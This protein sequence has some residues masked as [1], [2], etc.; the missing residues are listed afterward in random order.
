MVWSPP[1]VISL[2]PPSLD[3]G[4]VLDGGDGLADVE[5][6]DRHVAG[7]GHLL[8]GEGLHV[9]PG[10]VGPEQLGRGPDVSGPEPRTGP[11]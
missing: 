11:V 10:V 5:R 2:V 8:H 7:V 1:K 4:G 9:Q 6:V 3:V